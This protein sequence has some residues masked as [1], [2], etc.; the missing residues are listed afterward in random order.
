MRY[1]FL[2]S[3]YTYPPY[4]PTYITH[5]RSQFEDPDIT[6]AAGVSS[7]LWYFLTSLESL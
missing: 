2:L 5:E 6:F 7:V 4:S 1:N 3:P